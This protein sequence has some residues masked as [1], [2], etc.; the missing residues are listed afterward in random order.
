MS[1]N[2]Q[3][4]NCDAEVYVDKELGKV[5]CGCCM[6]VIDIADACKDDW[7]LKPTNFLIR[8]G[9]L[10]KY[11]GQAS[12][13]IHTPQGVKS[14]GYGAFGFGTLDVFISDGVE[15]IK[16]GAFNCPYLMHLRIPDSIKKFEN[17]IDEKNRYWSS[18]AIDLQRMV[19]V[20]PVK[21]VIECS[22]RVKEM[23]LADYNKDERKLV[24]E[25]VTW[26]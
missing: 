23:L 4:Q 18:W 19:E 2:I 6:Q 5:I 13:D 24:E 12:R 14:I 8:D 21:P 10:K 11:L 26:K 15:E 25:G 20:N 9:E 17:H 1:I 16:A 3:C 7:K 22:N